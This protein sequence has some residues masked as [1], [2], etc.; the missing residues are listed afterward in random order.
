MNIRIPAW[1]GG[2]RSGLPPGHYWLPGP[3]L[4][5]VTLLLAYGFV[6][7]TLTIN[8]AASTTFFLLALIG[9][10]VGLRRGFTNGLT[11]GEKI[12][13]LGIV[14]Y[15][16]F[17][18]ASYV[19]GVQTNTG[20]RIIGRDL[21]F[22]LFIPIYLAIRWSNPRS[23]HVGYAL[24]AGALGAFIAALVQRQPWPAPTPHGV[25]GTH[26]T[27]GDL[28][29]LS[30]VLAAWLLRPRGEGKVASAGRTLLRQ[31]RVWVPVSCGI[32]AVLLAGARGGWV[33][34]P[35]ALILAAT[36]SFGHTS[37]KR[38]RFGISLAVVSL[39]IGAVV[40]G[41]H[42]LR[43]RATRAWRQWQEYRLVTTPSVL[44]APCVDQANSLKALLIASQLRGPGT[45]DVVR[46]SPR[47]RVKASRLGCDG[48]YALSLRASQ[49]GTRPFEVRLYRG[50]WPAKANK[51]QRAKV[52]AHG[53]G[54]VNIGWK[55]PWVQVRALDSWQPYEVEHS[56]AWTAPLNFRLLPNSR[57]LVI[58]IQMKRG[59]FAIPL[60]RSSVGLR[61]EMWRAAWNMFLR[62]PLLGVGTGAFG[63]QSHTYLSAAWVQSGLATNFEHAHSDYLT[64]LS[65][66]GILGLVSFIALLIAPLLVHRPVSRRNTGT[67]L[68]R[69]SLFLSMSTA[70]A[71]FGLTETMFIHSLVIS[72]YVLVCALLVVATRFQSESETN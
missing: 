32:A 71:L 61:L 11:R 17:A 19:V 21:R 38:W 67:Y 39:L 66:K 15:P 22:L 10:Y 7:L 69:S 72:W 55:A 60:V 70:F 12:L 45:A 59:E 41:S 8:Y 51:Q 40:G 50:N 35:I 30:G 43:H 27:F 44:D 28:S 42:A 26:I 18:I 29:L 36:A 1:V 37:K 20:F 9:M 16:V 48:G 49:S 56:Y 13:M 58:P 52:L 34:I 23:H 14:A 64:S 4:R 54:S 25:A 63:P 24:A 68:S 57:L 33:F 3:A 2:S 31:A 47:L 62:H 5:F 53:T 46:L 6:A 65:T